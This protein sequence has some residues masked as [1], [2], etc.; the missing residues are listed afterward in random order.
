MLQSLVGGVGGGVCRWFGSGLDWISSC[1]QIP[2][3]RPSFEDWLR[4]VGRIR[5]D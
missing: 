3:R 5:H 4:L 1:R 2:A